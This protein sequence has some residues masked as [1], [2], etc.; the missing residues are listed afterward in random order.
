MNQAFPDAP[1][2]VH[3]WL[4]RQTQA[5]HHQLDHSPLLQALMQP[6]LTPAVY[7]DCLRHLRAAHNITEPW[8]R[9]LAGTKPSALPAYQ[10]RLIALDHDIHALV[11]HFN[12]T[13]RPGPTFSSCQ[14]PAAFDAS[15]EPSLRVRQ[16]HYLGVRYVLEGAS[17]GA[18]VISARLQKSSP[19]LLEASSEYWLFQSRMMSNWKALTEQLDGVQALCPEALLR[20]AQLAFRQFI[21][22][23]NTQAAPP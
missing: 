17:Q 12:I 4:R 22:V 19:Q 13:P 5:L 6:P 1:D 15:T 7:V 21:D 11:H 16:S 9:A 20:G 8:I 23:F 18:R 14:L 3:V 10:S 2:G